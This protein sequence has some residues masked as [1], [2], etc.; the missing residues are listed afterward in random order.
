MSGFLTVV[1]R[2]LVMIAGPAIIASVLLATSV[3]W[4]RNSLAYIAGAALAITLV[5]TA[6]FLRANGGEGSGGSA[7]AG[8]RARAT[9]AVIIALLVLVAAVVYRRR[10]RTEPPKWMGKLQDAE[11]K[12]AFGLGFLVLG[13]FPANIITSIT[14]GSKLSREGVEWFHVLTFLLVTLCLLGIPA[15]IV[16]AL[17]ERANVFLPNVRDWMNTNSW[18]VSEIVIALFIGIGI[19]GLVSLS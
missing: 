18:I 2:T 7:L 5:L 1:P 9:D 16:L 3:R 10:H 12:F 15:V 8:N 17:G 6:A 4:A 11:P 19:V 13:F 14:V